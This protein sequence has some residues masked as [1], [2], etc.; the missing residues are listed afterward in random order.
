MLK[1]ILRATSWTAALLVLATWPGAAP[2]AAQDS[3]IT[4]YSAGSAARQRAREARVLERI[5]PAELDATSQALSRE[6]HVAGSDAQARTRDWVLEQTRS[7][8]LESEAPTYTV[9]LPWAT[10]VELEQI[11]PARRRFDLR[12]P[13]IEGDP[14]TSAPQYPLVLGYSG[15]GQVEAEVVYLNYGLHEDYAQLDSLGVSVAGKIVIARYGR[16]FRGIKA[17]L[18]EQH[19]AVGLII[20]PDPADDGYVRGDVYPEG[21]FRNDSGVQRGSVMNG[22]GDPTTPG[23]ASV[24]GARRVEPGTA[25]GIELPTIPVITVSYGVAQP[26]LEALR[27]EE[28]P[29]QGWQGGLPFRYHVGPGPTRVR[30]RVQDDRETAA[31]KEIW[32]TVAWVRGADRPD[33]W[34]IVGGHRDG[35]G[36]GANDNNSGTAAVL[37]AAK[38][39]AELAKAGERPRRTIVFATWD[40][41]EWGLIGSTE[42]VEE[43]A[44]ELGLKA[45]AYINQ[46]AVATGPAFGA[47]ASPSLKSFVREVTRAV[48]APAL[49]DRRTAVRAAGS[50]VSG[51]SV[52][53]RWRAG[54]PSASAPGAPGEVPLGNLGGGSDFAGF[55]NHLGIPS[56]G[57]GFGG[58]WGQYHSAYDTYA[59]MSRFGDPGFVHHATTAKLAAVAALRLA[60]AEILPYDYVEFARELRAVA[61]ALEQEASARG[62]AEVGM[63]ALDRAF[64][65]MEEAALEF[66]GARD[67]WLGHGGAG[68]PAARSASAADSANH[69]LMRV[70]RA[71]TRPEGLV[72][73]PWYRNLI[74]ASDDRNGYA[75]IGLPSVAEAILSGDAARVRREVEDLAARVGE[76]TEQIRAA[77]RFLTEGRG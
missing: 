49:A 69:R 40:A 77:T 31:F 3:S 43:L 70:E 24:A 2:A 27:G 23:W 28:L 73:R 32:N 50:S 17:R 4:G 44:R 71:M 13:P 1:P 54:T 20:Y 33:E 37:A 41:E 42:W 8:G 19:G 47:S 60:N 74:F 7:W 34:I 56:A 67:Q 63:A 25:A 39:V 18:A 10:E 58:G 22:V 14:V 55:Y 59:W 12:E 36:A 30:M 26:I 68:Q 65:A 38:A 21:T 61:A 64:A 45:V 76:A 75:T 11:A 46:D 35:W 16:S 52:Y 66:A 53:D 9:Y 6:P 48:P 29:D 57:W 62:M 51:E 72:G 15:V 5:L